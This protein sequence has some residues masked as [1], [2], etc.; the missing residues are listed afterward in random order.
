VEPTVVVEAHELVDG[1]LD[2]QLVR[3][4]TERVLDAVEVEGV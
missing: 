3:L 2:L 1:G 4:A